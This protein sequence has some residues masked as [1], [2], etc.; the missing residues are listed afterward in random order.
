MAIALQIVASIRMYWVLKYLSAEIFVSKDNLNFATN[1][2][3]IAQNWNVCLESQSHSAILIDVQ[4]L[5]KWVQLFDRYCTQV[6]HSTCQ[7]GPHSSLSDFALLYA[8]ASFEAMVL[9]ICFCRQRKHKVKWLF[10]RNDAL[11]RFLEALLSIY[12]TRVPSWLTFLNW[13]FI[14]GYM[15]RVWIYRHSRDLSI[16]VCSH[17]QTGASCRCLFTL[18]ATDSWH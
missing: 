11:Y 16:S 1:L 13:L 5:H 6:G 3:I 18:V 9:S 7:I 17:P 14:C 4:D 8:R 15:Y 2:N 10:R 12:A